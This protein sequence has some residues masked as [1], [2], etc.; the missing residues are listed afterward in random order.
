MPE[1]STISQNVQVG[2]ETTSGTAV[3]ATKRLTSLTIRPGVQADVKTFR[4]Q[5]TKFATVTALGK[6]SSAAAIEGQPVYDELVY[7]LS[8]LLGAAVITTPDGAGAP[9]G[10]LW[11]FSPSSTAEDT[12]KTFTVEVG[13]SVRAH[14]IAY[15]LVTDLTIGGNR[16]ELSVG[17]SMIGQAL[18][19][20]ITLTAGPTDLPLVPIL[21]SQVSVYLDTTSGGLGGTKLTRVLSWEWAV[22][23]KY[24]P[25]WVV[26][27]AVPSFAAHLESEPSAAAQLTVEAD[28]AGMALLT[29]LRSGATRFL[30]IEAIGATIG[31]AVTYRLR[32]D[33]AVKVSAVADFTDEDGV[34]AI[35]FTLAAV[36]DGTWGKAMQVSLQNTTAAL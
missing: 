25:L 9:T 6:E 17:G 34:Y 12:P 10:R 20:G 16:D 36:H 18:Q 11:T 29:L 1:R 7:P 33:Q 15:G 3:A 14:R 22:G 32:I 21:P 2:V 5:G 35:Q 31:A 23:S 13:S 30:R 24:A 26:D 28:A 19:D 4:P 27:A 8:G